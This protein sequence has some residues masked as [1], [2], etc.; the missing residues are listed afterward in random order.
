MSPDARVSV[1]VPVRDGALYLG[2]ALQSIAEQTLRPHEV[3]VVDD[4]STDGS[5]ALAERL[6]ARVERQPAS[7][8]AAARN[9]G[10]ECSTGEL[11][12]FL[13]ADDLW[14]PDSLELRVAALRSDPQVELVFGHARQF[15]AEAR[16]A[17]DEA[18]PAL[19]HGTM[20]ARR[21]TLE[22][23]GPLSCEWRV[24]DLMDWLFRARDAGVR[25]LMIDAVVLLRRLHGA[26]VSRDHDTRMDHVRVVRQALDRRRGRV[27]G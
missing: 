8:P 5:A 11:V 3:I 18:R 6:G 20:L 9:R 15:K 24:G 25:E 2:E 10:A 21:R 26:N 17:L 19:L 27:G 12:G 16:S 23:V 7:G 13:D 1:V 4:G 22:R 14:P